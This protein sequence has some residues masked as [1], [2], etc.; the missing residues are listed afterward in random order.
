MTTPAAFPETQARNAMRTQRRQVRELLSGPSSDV[1]G[2]AR[3][4]RLRVA[5]QRAGTKTSQ[6]G[7]VG[8]QYQAQIP[9]SCTT[10]SND[11]ETD[12]DCDR[13]GGAFADQKREDTCDGENI[14]EQLWLP[15]GDGRVLI[16]TRGPS[17]QSRDPPPSAI[18]DATAAK[19][20]AGASSGKISFAH[21]SS[22]GA[23]PSV[24]DTGLGL[25]S[26]C[27]THKLM[28]TPVVPFFADA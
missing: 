2:A 24:S 6:L 9:T 22:A 19:S 4:K 25:Q 12:C 21:N 17:Q 15:V 28:R 5:S 14:G 18:M 13:G 10:A 16:A 23:L 11:C 20:G 26:H 1:D 8:P 7:R 3:P 27:G